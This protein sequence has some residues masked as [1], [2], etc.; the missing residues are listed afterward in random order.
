M[1][2]PRQMLKAKLR[3]ASAATIQASTHARNPAGGRSR[4]THARRREEDATDE[5]GET[6]GRRVLLRDARLG[7]CPT[8]GARLDVEESRGT[9]RD[10]DATAAS[11]ISARK[12][13]T[14]A[15]AGYAKPDHVGGHDDH[16]QDHLVDLEDAAVEGNGWHRVSEKHTR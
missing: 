5:L 9:F 8:D 12:G 14:Q 1:M 15:M 13:S 10:G 7:R 4:R 11:I 6:M 2:Q 3:N 16:H